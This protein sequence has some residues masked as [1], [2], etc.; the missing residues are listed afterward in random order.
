MGRWGRPY[1]FEENGGDGG[2]EDG[3]WRRERLYSF[4][5][6]DNRNE[7][8]LLFLFIFCYLNYSATVL[9]RTTKPF[10]QWSVNTDQSSNSALPETDLPF[11]K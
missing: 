11:S 10:Q 8:R 9:N 7:S 6:S 1:G 4:Q 5:N 3:K 2:K